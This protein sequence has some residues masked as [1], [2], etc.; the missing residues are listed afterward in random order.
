MKDQI[1]SLKKMG[2]EFTHFRKESRKLNKLT[3]SLQVSS[4]KRHLDGIKTKPEKKKNMEN[5]KRSF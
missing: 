4:L 5:S 1:N 2:Q 3:K